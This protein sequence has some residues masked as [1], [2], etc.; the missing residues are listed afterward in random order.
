MSELYQT[1][2]QDPDATSVDNGELALR[3]AD[4]NEFDI[5]REA[6]S[7][8]DDQRGRAM[9]AIADRT[10]GGGTLHTLQTGALLTMFD[11]LTTDK[12]RAELYADMEDETGIS[13]TQLFRTLA[14][15]RV[16][17]RN[18]L[19]DRETA[20]RCTCEGL[21]LLAGKDVAEAARTE[22]LEF[23]RAGNF[24]T[25]KVAKNLIRKHARR[26]SGQGGEITEKPTSAG[27]ATSAAASVLWQHRESQLQ[28]V[29]RRQSQSVV[30]DNETIVL[31]L[32]AAL[33]AY[34]RVAVEQQTAPQVA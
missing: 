8:D 10:R 33:A 16:Y 19:H 24:L 13:R 34:K 3:I 31:A 21:K 18:L 32:E 17:G 7:L 5:N 26:H 23:A 9:A 28:V 22:A 6:S 25:I 29:V 2:L 4:A 27:A 12:T 1:L 14:M 11:H 20:S 15:F 30:V